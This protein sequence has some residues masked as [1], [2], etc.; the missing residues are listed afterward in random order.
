MKETSAPQETPR[1]PELTQTSRSP[2][3]PHPVAMIK[4]AQAD[5]DGQVLGYGLFL[6]AVIE[7]GCRTSPVT[8]EGFNQPRSAKKPR[9]HANSRGTLYL[10]GFVQSLN[11]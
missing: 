3:R 9:S 1:R 10:P 7:G 5:L 11:L 2:L 8:E 6:S 4:E